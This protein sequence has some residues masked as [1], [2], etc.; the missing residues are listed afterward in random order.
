MSRTDHATSSSST[1]HGDAT[2]NGSAPSWATRTAE[3]M[4]AALA[5]AWSRGWQP[6]DVD[7]ALGRDDRTTRVVLRRAILAEAAT[8]AGPERAVPA[9]WR[10]QLDAISAELPAA[11]DPWAA[12]VAAVASAPVFPCNMLRVGLESLADV[13]AFTAPPSAWGRAGSGPAPEGPAP[14]AVLERVRALLAKAESTEFEAEAEAFTAKAQELITRHSIDAVLVAA[15]D[16]GSARPPVTGRTVHV[17][18]PYAKE[19][20]FLLSTVAEANGCRTIYSPGYRIVTC[21]GLP[22]DLEAVDLLYTSLLL[23]STTAVLSAEAPRLLGRR[24]SSSKASFR[25]SF[26]LAFAQRIGVRLDEARHTAEAQAATDHGRDLLPVL[27][28]RDSAVAAAVDEAFPRT[29]RSRFTVGDA[30]G[31]AAGDAA[32]A[33]AT[34]GDAGAV[35]QA[36]RGALGSR[37]G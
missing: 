18:D 16:D 35:R 33:R 5:S 9:S 27:A 4:V 34:L 37:T 6:R 25:R 22:D 36:R 30:A 28:S 11:A 32:G 1:D 15:R 12:L 2:T 10:A 17:E 24:S 14:T 7:W 13:P 20:W 26:L 3:Q 8:S 19:K 31:A 21:F 23:Q 29:R